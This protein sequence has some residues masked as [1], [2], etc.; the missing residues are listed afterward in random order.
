MRKEKKKTMPLHFSTFP[1]VFHIVIHKKAAPCFF[2]DREQ[3][4]VI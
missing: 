4:F 3:F 2:A 1:H